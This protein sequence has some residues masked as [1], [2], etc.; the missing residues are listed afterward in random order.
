[1][2]GLT[3]RRR[4]A[5]QI[6]LRRALN[7]SVSRDLATTDWVWKQGDIVEAPFQI[8]NSQIQERS[9]SRAVRKL[10]RILAANPFRLLGE[11]R[12]AGKLPGCDLQQK[13]SRSWRKLKPSE[14]KPT[15]SG[16]SLKP[17]EHSR[18]S[19]RSRHSSSTYPSTWQL[20]INKAKEEPKE[21]SNGSLDEIINCSILNRTPYD[22]KLNTP[23]KSDNFCQC[24]INKKARRRSRKSKVLPGDPAHAITES[25]RKNPSEE[26]SFEA[27]GLFQRLK[28]RVYSGEEFGQVR[29]I[30]RKSSKNSGNSKISFGCKQNCAGRSYKNYGGYSPSETDIEVPAEYQPK[31]QGRFDYLSKIERISKPPSGLDN[32]WSLKMPS[33]TEIKQYMDNPAVD[34]PKYKPQDREVRRKISHCYCAK[35]KR[36]LNQGRRGLNNSN[37]SNDSLLDDPKYRNKIP[38]QASLLSSDKFSQRLNDVEGEDNLS[39]SQF[40]ASNI[41]QQNIISNGKNN[42]NVYQS[43]KNE[44]KRHPYSDP[45][46]YSSN[47][48]DNPNTGISAKYN[49]KDGGSYDARRV[50]SSE[51]PQAG[52]QRATQGF[53]SQDP[54]PGNWK[55]A[56]GEKAGKPENSGPKC[57]EA[58]TQTSELVITYRNSPELPYNAEPTKKGQKNVVRSNLGTANQ[59][60]DRQVRSVKNPQSQ[61]AEKNKAQ[62]S[63]P[64]V[65]NLVQSNSLII[66]S[67]E[68]QYGVVQSKQ[69]E[70]ESDQ[71]FYQSQEN[72]IRS[73]IGTV[74]QIKSGKATPRTQQPREMN[75]NPLKPSIPSKQEQSKPQKSKPTGL[76]LVQSNS[77][78]IESHEEHYDVVQSKEIELEPPQESYQSQ[79]SSVR[80]TVATPNKEHIKEVKS[81]KATPKTQHPRQIKRKPSKPSIQPNQDQSKPQKSKPT[82]L[83]L[84]QSSSFITESQEKQ[85]HLVQSSSIDLIAPEVTAPK[86][87]KV[88]RPRKRKRSRCCSCC[89]R[90]STRKRSLKKPNPSEKTKSKGHCDVRELLDILQKTVAG[91]EKQMNNRKGFKTSKNT[92]SKSKLNEAQNKHSIDVR[93]QHFPYPQEYY[94]LERSRFDRG[95]NH[96][97]N[98]QYSS[99]TPTN[100]ERPRNAYQTYYDK[101]R[102]GY[103]GANSSN[104]FPTN[105][106]TGFTGPISLSYGAS[107]NS[108]ELSAFSYQNQRI[109]K[110]AVP[111]NDYF[112][113]DLRPY[114]IK[115]MR[116]PNS[117]NNEIPN[118][119]YGQPSADIYHNNTYQGES[120]PQN[121][122]NPATL[123]VP[124]GSEEP[125]RRNEHDYPKEISERKSQPYRNQEPFQEPIGITN[126]TQ[127]HTLNN[128]TNQSL[129]QPMIGACLCIGN[130]PQVEVHEQNPFA[131]KPM[132]DSAYSQGSKGPTKLESQNPKEICR[133]PEFCPFSSLNNAYDG[134]RNRGP[135]TFQEGHTDIPNT[136]RALTQKPLQ[137]CDNSIYPYA[138]Q[139]SKSWNSPSY[140]I[141]NETQPYPNE[142]DP[143]QCNP[144][145]VYEQS[146]NSGCCKGPEYCLYRNNR[147]V[148]TFE[149][150]NTYRNYQDPRK[151]GANSTD[152]EAM[153]YSTSENITQSYPMESDPTADDIDCFC[154]QKERLIPFQKGGTANNS[155]DF[156][157]IPH[158]PENKAF[159]NVSSRT[160]RRQT[161]PKK[162]SIYRSS[163]KYHNKEELCECP[164]RQV[165]LE[166]S[167][168]A[169][170][171]KSFDQS[172]N[173][174]FKESYQTEECLLTCPTRLKCSQDDK[175]RGG[176]QITIVSNHR[177]EGKDTRTR[178]NKPSCLEEEDLEPCSNRKCPKGLI[179]HFCNNQQYPEK[180]LNR[181][182]RAKQVYQNDIPNDICENQNCPDKNARNREPYT[183]KNSIKGDRKWK[184]ERQTQLEE[185]TED[186]DSQDSCPEDCPN[187][188]FFT[189][190][191]DRN[192]DATT[193]WKT[194]ENPKCSDRSKRLSNREV[195]Y[196]DSQVPEKI[197]RPRT[198]RY[199]KACDNSKCPNKNGIY[200]DQN[201][202]RTY[203]RLGSQ[204]KYDQKLCENAKCTDKN[205]MHKKRNETGYA[206]SDSKKANSERRASYNEKRSTGQKKD[207]NSIC[208]EP[209]YPEGKE[210]DNDIHFKEDPDLNRSNCYDRQMS[211]INND[212]NNGFEICDNPNCPG[213]FREVGNKKNY[214]ENH[215][216]KE[217][218]ENPHCPDKVNKSPKRYKY[219]MDRE[220]CPNDKCYDADELDLCPMECP[221]RYRVLFTDLR[222]CKTKTNKTS[223]QSSGRADVYDD[224][225]IRTKS[226]KACKRYIPLE[227]DRQA[228]NNYCKPCRIEAAAK[229]DSV[230]SLVRAVCI[231]PGKEA[232][233]L[234]RNRHNPLVTDPIFNSYDKHILKNFEK[235][236]EENKLRKCA[237]DCPFIGHMEVKEI[238]QKSSSDC[239]CEMEH[240]E[241][242]SQCDCSEPEIVECEDTKNTKSKVSFFGCCTKSPKDES[243]SEPEPQRRTKPVQ[244]DKAESKS[245][246]FSCFKR[247]EK[248]PQEKTKPKE[249]SAS[250]SSGFSCFKKKEKPPQEEPKPK[251]KTQSKLSGFSYFKKKEKVPQE[252]AKPKE[253]SPAST[254][255]SGFLCFK[256]TEKRP[257]EVKV[258]N[259]KVKD[260]SEKPSKRSGFFGWCRKSDAP[261]EYRRKLEDIP[262]TPDCT[263]RRDADAKE[264][265]VPMLQPGVPFRCPCAPDDL[266]DGE[267]K[268]LYDSSFRFQKESC[269]CAEVPKTTICHNNP[270]NPE[271]DTSDWY[272]SSAISCRQEIEEQEI[273]YC[274][275][276]SAN[277]FYKIVR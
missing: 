112:N 52:S 136:E 231:S 138:L 75:R 182:G 246:G 170:N 118:P 205:N 146:I 234:V 250:K 36:N 152:Q 54:S 157:G 214:E 229:N 81:G 259:E 266:D 249:R 169:E 235:Y 252:E 221:E 40:G 155:E 129:N 50:P 276:A 200:G 76:N 19:T 251:E 127:E 194:Y 74:K 113:K 79:A 10:H 160:E 21:N 274:P 39:Q 78:I 271:Q 147:G 218:C 265:E 230:E 6:L 204:K 61:E 88:I 121:R 126:G 37:F 183:V 60:N 260:T 253:K 220:K 83:S 66:E 177:R 189:N 163:H 109:Q 34:R 245:S 85:Y 244:K 7:K 124:Y 195:L 94:N 209:N 213:R 193:D 33:N 62:L 55:R 5:Q 71:E 128:Y 236:K 172:R 9:S 98:Q 31:L 25:T 247:K 277:G 254:K 149:D 222:R 151:V 168:Y 267:V 101:R 272:A 99:N 69:V 150:S 110:E 86:P 156:C 92:K 210:E 135:I 256:K 43:N 11:R 67:H 190:L 64:T 44:S 239:S 95:M 90:C 223:R 144:E 30:C 158:C 179:D 217:V 24:T 166:H 208:H 202:Y 212:I 72:S 103:D 29:R 65:L 255:S 264:E 13:D 1:M 201:K 238:A 22:H 35:R 233:V 125:S 167:N 131:R 87:K 269:S 48:S 164:E 47:E 241:Y 268:V 219:S 91:L 107:P 84:V 120:L 162:E 123:E 140:P 116:G 114:N 178:N 100:F 186:V 134:Q 42:A 104:I 174:N 148:V 237:E 17:N 261:K 192:K 273:P 57:V 139:N 26:R 226:C 137:I 228:I 227:R 23:L 2:T 262:P 70:V 142:I 242:T 18:G 143:P 257:Q 96:S 46:E 248:P 53:S 105:S 45:E 77:L 258:K 161:Y 141:S 203:N 89:S 4:T 207:Q 165:L 184:G 263:C 58:I 145:C 97:R 93:A 198:Q 102:W 68:E 59:E 106:N 32:K 41:Y 14:N 119:N 240:Q 82:G 108:V 117:L 243:K 181:Y 122:A 159:E 180:I 175:R 206:A 3:R 171:R 49:Q 8:R 199:D 225:P 270:Q 133:G 153:Q 187:R 63:E 73:N 224:S 38:S 191:K 188:E 130:S 275:C 196:K 27:C 132:T 20:N 16:H 185:M 111:E 176:P 28:E 173:Q 215:Y 197:I 232:P 80:S 12:T 15:L 211:R 115:D 216:E 51:Y 56:S 154:D